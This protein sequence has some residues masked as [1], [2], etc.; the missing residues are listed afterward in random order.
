MT[1]KISIITIVKNGMPY[2]KDSINSFESQSHEN[3]EHIIIVSPS[4]DETEKFLKSNNLKNAK[5]FFNNEIKGRYEAINY[6]IKKATGNIIGLLH[7]DDLFF[8]SSV[9]SLVSQ[10]FEEADC[11]YGNI[12]FCKRNDPSKIIRKWKSSKFDKTKFK[13]G[14]SIPHTS[15]F[16]KKNI[17]MNSLYD[18]N[19]DISADYDFILNLSLKKNIKIKYINFISTVMRVGGDSTNILKFTKKLKE[20]LNILKKYFSLYYIVY[21][22]KIFRKIPQI[23]R[24]NS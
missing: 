2:L 8:N 1:N 7:A 17:M 20:D 22:L 18:N 13:Y 24:M 5:I 12:V 3:K 15:I 21:V 4:T 10:N 11:I 9:L 14:W 6:G 23:I 16:I 19:Y